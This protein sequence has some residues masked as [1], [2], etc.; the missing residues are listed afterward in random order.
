MPNTPVITIDGPSGSGKGTIAARVADAL[1]WHFLDSGALYRLVGL[2]AGRAD[3]DTSDPDGLAR[4]ARALDVEF[5]GDRILL[6]G[7]DVT[8][9][10]RT[11]TAGNAASRVAAVPEVRAALLEWQRAKA[12]APG[13]VADG[14]DMGSVVFPDA[15]VKVFLTAS[16]DE[17]ARRRH[18]QLREKGIEINIAELAAEIRERDE[19]DRN[20]A[21]APLI[22]PPGA[23]EIDSTG[24]SIDQ[25]L[26]LVLQR[27]QATFPGLTLGAGPPIR[28]EV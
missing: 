24:L 27:V 7:E 18:N 14:R 19:R 26:A 15:P 10:I 20:R 28:S 17:R 5:A 3:C 12:Q 13:L 16:A 23:L 8:L 6:G 11:E 21:V 4:I 9:A 1:G 25:V 2:A 22:A